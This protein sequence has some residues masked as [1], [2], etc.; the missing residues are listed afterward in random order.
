MFKWDKKNLR[1]VIKNFDLVS[2]GVKGSQG[3]DVLY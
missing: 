1:S 2:T 3:E